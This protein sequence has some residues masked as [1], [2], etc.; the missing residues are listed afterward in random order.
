MCSLLKVY[1]VCDKINSTEP[2]IFC[3]YGSNVA[4]FVFFVFKHTICILT[5]NGECHGVVARTQNFF[6]C[7][8]EKDPFKSW[9]TLY[10]R[11][12]FAPEKLQVDSSLAQIWQ[13]YTLELFASMLRVISL[14][15][16]A[17]RCFLR[18][19]ST[20]FCMYSISNM[21]GRL[22]LRWP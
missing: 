13:D 12:Q 11:E 4:Y 2:C 19:F 22:L 14:R 16:K 3:F 10:L 20:T 5:N 21:F 17:Y 8:S 15:K 1:T 6:F 7:G 18:S 9:T